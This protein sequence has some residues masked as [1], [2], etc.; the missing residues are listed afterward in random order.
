LTATSSMSRWWCTA[1][2]SR[3]SWGVC[4]APTISSAASS[5]YDFLSWCRSS[6]CGVYMSSSPTQALLNSIVQT[7]KKQPI[8][9]IHRHH[10]SL[11]SV[12]GSKFVNCVV[13]KSSYN[14]K[15]DH[16][17]LINVLLG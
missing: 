3:P 8:P 2:C 9:P 15:I 14:F 4:Q 6:R 13:Y 5:T 10:S 11:W 12:N 16:Q 17:D 7:G 1:T